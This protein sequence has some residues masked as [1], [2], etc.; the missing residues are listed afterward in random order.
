[1]YQHAF[2]PPANHHITNGKCSYLE[3]KKKLNEIAIKKCR[4]VNRNARTWCSFPI[5]R[6]SNWNG[7][8]V[9]AFRMRFSVLTQYVDF[10]HNVVVFMEASFQW[11]CVCVCKCVGVLVCTRVCV[12]NEWKCMHRFRKFMEFMLIKQ[13]SPNRV[14]PSRQ[15]R[16]QTAQLFSS[17]SPFATSF[18]QPEC[19]TCACDTPYQSSTRQTSV[20]FS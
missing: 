1:M 9:M 16:S 3:R 17:V 13:F 11:A 20:C 8:W 7:V 15:N 4:L 10:M 12:G 19:E 2:Q 5:F 6:K 14:F 18:A